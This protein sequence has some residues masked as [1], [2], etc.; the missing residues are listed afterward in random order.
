MAAV[1]VITCS[2][3]QTKRSSRAK[4]RFTFFCSG[5]TDTGLVFWISIAV[6][7][8]P[9]NSG[10]GFPAE[11]CPDPRL[12]E[13]ADFGVDEVVALDHRLVETEDPAVRMEG[14]ASLVLP[15]AGHGGDA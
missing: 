7:G 14:A 1:S 12:V 2:W 11:D 6:T 8:G 3:T 4:P 5:A 13:P 9:S 10:S 15:G